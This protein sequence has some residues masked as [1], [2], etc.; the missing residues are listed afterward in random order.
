[1]RVTQVLIARAARFVEY[2]QPPYYPDVI[3]RLQDRYAFVHVPTTPDEIIPRVENPAAGILSGFLHGKLEH[4]GRT[5]VI[6]SLTFYS[7]AVAVESVI[8]TEDAD[9]VLDDLL[10]QAGDLM[11]AKARRSYAS[12]LE[13]SADV[14]LWRTF[15]VAGALGQAMSKLQAGYGGPSAGFDISS[16]TISSDPTKGSEEELVI[17]RR[18]N[19]AFDSNL[20]YSHAPLSSPHHV[21]LL[22]SAETAISEVLSS[23]SASPTEPPPPSSQSPSSDDH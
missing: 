4:D 1:M 12:G 11:V 13:F 2:P 8:S 21:T 3:R 6:K 15:R 9:V 19:A 23:A 16:I 18:V 20:F 10:A 7:D 5:I 14:P 22:E 17:A